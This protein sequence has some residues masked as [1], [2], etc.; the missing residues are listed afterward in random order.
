L[1]RWSDIPLPSALRMREALR[2]GDIQIT[3]FWAALVGLLAACIAVAF[4]E[5]LRGLQWL[6]WWHTDDLALG[7]GAA[8]YWQRLLVPAIGGLLAGLVLH[9]GRRW[10][11]G[12]RSRE[13]LEVVAIG[14]GTIPV[15]PSLVTCGSALF[16]IASGGSIGREGVLVQLASML[17]SWVGRFAEL[18][19]PRREL[20]VACGAAAG[21]ASAYNAPLAGALFVSEIALASIAMETLGPLVLSSVVATATTRALLGPQPLFEIPPFQ[22]VS[23]FELVPYALLGVVAGALAPLWV[24]GLRAS[25]AAFERLNLP[26]WACMALG[27]LGVGALALVRPEVFGNG[28]GPIGAI[29]RG[30]YVFT[31][32]ALVLVLKLVATALTAGSGA[33]GGVFTPTL[34]AGAAVGFLLGT[35]LHA[36]VPEW[37]GSSGAYAL[38]GMGAFLAAATQAPLV[39]IVMLVELTL[40]YG[41]LLPLMLAC[42]IAYTTARSLAAPSLYQHRRRAPNAILPERVRD[43]MK[44]RPL[45]LRDDAPFR[46]LVRVFEEHRHNYV[47]VTDADGRFLGAVSLHEIKPHLS[48][49]ELTRDVVARD[50]LHDEF[51]RLEQDASLVSALEAFRRHDGE[52]LPV[53]DGNGGSMLVGSISKTD[54]LLSLTLDR[55]RL[56]SEPPDGR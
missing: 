1:K 34:F 6:L 27:G 4:R 31:T 41:I 11:S 5:A 15:R 16:T 32:V 30:N 47:Y 22:L 14:G 8:S 39:A 9:L 51:P 25:E 48:K 19:R 12:E 36:L 52:R 20:L 54:L 50:L 42:V 35:P 17:S 3:L 40:D 45:A 2:P 10:F 29:L 46:E 23:V 26:L 18:A 37:T 33:H 53:I 7:T 21:I 13:Y 44:P 38:V 43:L 28:A 24:R 49:P 55:S 56:D